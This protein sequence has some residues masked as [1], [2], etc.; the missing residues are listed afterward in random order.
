MNLSDILVVM[1]R[2]PAADV[3]LELAMS[4][5]SRH[6]ARLSGICYAEPGGTPSPWQDEV[7]ALFME[8]CEEIDI[9]ARW[10][11][12]G[13]ARLTHLAHSS[14]LIV[15]G[16]SGERGNDSVPADLPE[17]LVLSTGRP[18]VTVPYTGRFIPRCE[19]I[20]VAWSDGRES[21]RA[22]HDAMPLLRR[23]QK[24][25]IVNL[26][27][28]KTAINGAEERLQEIVGHLCLY[29]VKV[30]GEMILS[31]DFPPGDMLLNRACEERSDLLVMGA[32]NQAGNGKPV[33]GPVARHI[34]RQMTLPVLMSH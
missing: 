14:D 22:L 8:K 18:V 13:L 12:Q 3:R 7:A 1:D 33:L 19:R 5:A 16:Q 20:L 15:V 11:G 24:V 29:G 31:I 25:H 23:A 17:R 26:V 27:T 32:Y 30:K 28:E 6:G 34:L 4:Y 2:S 10:C 21:S 9:N